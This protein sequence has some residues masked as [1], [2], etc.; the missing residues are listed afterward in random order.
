MGAPVA[1][2][3][4]RGLRPLVAWTLAALG[5]QFLLG[6]LVNLFV[7]I[8]AGHPGADVGYFAG[9]PQVVAWAVGSGQLPLRVHVLLGLGLFAAGIV[10]WSWRSARGGGRGS[11]R[12]PSGCSASSAPRATGRAF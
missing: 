2:T 12:R 10:S 8:P 4:T 6:M 9:V 7:Q 1:G 3:E 5:V 11:G